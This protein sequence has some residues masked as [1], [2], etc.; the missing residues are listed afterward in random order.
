MSET[1]AGALYRLLWEAMPG[2]PR[3]DMI[4]AYS[5]IAS[6]PA[7]SPVINVSVIGNPLNGIAP[8]FAAAVRRFELREVDQ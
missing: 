5:L 7:H 3:P 1:P 6:D 4:Y 8:E 2:L